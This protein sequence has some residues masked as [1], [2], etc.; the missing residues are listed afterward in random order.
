MATNLLFY[1]SGFI[2]RIKRYLHVI[3]FGGLVGHVKNCCIQLSTSNLPS[4]LH[5]PRSGPV[6]YQPGGFMPHP[7]ALHSLN[8]HSVADKP[9]IRSQE[10]R[11]AWETSL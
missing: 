9:G 2:P 4:F 6:L 1:I 3:Y 8:R 11:I 10:P 5:T 7:N